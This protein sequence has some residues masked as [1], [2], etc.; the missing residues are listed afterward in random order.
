MSELTNL[1]ILQAYVN[2]TNEFVNR[3]DA[4]T[5]ANYNAW[6]SAVVEIPEVR[7]SF[8]SYLVNK[9]GK[10]YVYNIISHNPLQFLVNDTLPFGATVEGIW[11]EMAKGK[12]FDNE[13]KETLDKKV[14]DVRVL[15]HYVNSDLVYK[16]SVSDKELRKA[17]FNEG[18]LATLVQAITNTLY[19]GM[20][21]D[22]Y[23]YLKQLLADYSGYFYVKVPKFDGTETT[24]KE[25]GK[26][27]KA[28]VLY[29]DFDNV[30]FNG[31]GVINN[32]PS[33]NGL[34]I[35]TVAASVSLDFDY[36][37]NVFNLPKTELERRTVIVDNIAG[38][39]DA[40]CLY[41]DER[42]FKNYIVEESLETQRNAEGRFTNYTLV[43]EA[44]YSMCKYMTAI[45]FVT[46]DVID[47]KFDANGGTGEMLTKTALNNRKFCLPINRF[48]A[49]ANKKFVGWSLT[50]NGTGEIYKEMQD[51]IID[52]ENG[53]TEITIYA[54]W[55]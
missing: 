3:F 24:A 33:G 48:V 8:C 41:L 50:A 9:I 53:T 11:V 19:Q 13:G 55:Q 30:L 21:H 15:Y 37:A 35:M 18:G 38:F 31:A 23:L 5:Q 29:A 22:I 46:S 20:K 26:T 17:V 1:E 16:V 12:A 34:I 45:A 4:P 32:V 6:A 27:I 40:I 42:I 51:M 28:S 10:T 52:V 14:P 39:T 7:N 44:L 47:V 36:L 54:I 2:D 49:P 25:V 43:R